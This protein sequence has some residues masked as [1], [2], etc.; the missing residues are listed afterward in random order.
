M[1][2]KA[3]YKNKSPKYKF[4]CLL[5][6]FIFSFLIFIQFGNIAI[7]FFFDSDLIEN[8]NLENKQ[9]V[10]SLKV[11]QL[12]LA[13]GIFVVPMFLYAHLI[14]FDFKFKN[15]VRQNV[16]LVITIMLIIVP[17]IAMLTEFNLSIK[18]PD[19]LNQIDE[20]SDLTIA[21]LL[22]M[23]SNV[24]FL[25]NLLIIAIMPA[26][27]EELFF[28]GYLQQTITKWTI[29]PHIGIIITAILFSVIH[30]QFYGLIPRFILGVLLGYVFLWSNNL[31]LP[32]IAHFVN[33]AQ[34]LVI[35][36]VN[37]DQNS[38]M[39]SNNVDTTIGIFS[40]FGAALLMYLLYQSCCFRNNKI[41]KS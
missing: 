29:S 28:R 36:F 37:K 24:D 1:R 14:S 27:G 18:A 20:K 41:Q 4:F 9:Y 6:I 40:F 3:I 26:V 19:W 34:V 31:W 16:M 12:F 32:I 11:M 23:D 10:N 39:L 30:F 35:S 13:L 25:F 33:N 22:K 2:F 38:S 5:L 17:F 7:N 21:A 8:Q 15:L